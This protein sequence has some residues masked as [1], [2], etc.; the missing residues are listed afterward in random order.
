MTDRKRELGKIDHVHFGI[1][2]HGILS[3]AIGVDFGG[4]H[5]G[6]GHMVL[7][8]WSEKDK[9]RIGTAC[10][11]DLVLQ[12]LQF[13]KVDQ[14]DKIK[15]RTVFALRE[16]DSYNA[17]IVGLEIPPFDG[18]GKFLVKEWSARW[19]DELRELRDA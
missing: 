18:G 14:L 11:L 16:S 7:D 9:R 1:E 13:F 6:L 17:D 10:G 15:G 12:V 4:T 19:A 2:D 3:L 8:V 5:Q